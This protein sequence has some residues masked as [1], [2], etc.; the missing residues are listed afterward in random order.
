MRDIKL[1]LLCG[2]QRLP[3]YFLVQM[4]HLDFLKVGKRL[5]CCRFTILNS[6]LK[7]MHFLPSIC[8]LWRSLYG[9]PF[10]GSLPPTNNFPTSFIQPTVNFSIRTWCAHWSPTLPL[11]LLLCYPT[12]TIWL[13]DDYRSVPLSIGFVL[14]KTYFRLIF[15]WKR[16]TG[17]HNYIGF[18]F[19]SAQ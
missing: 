16:G 18:I 9:V 6:C 17:W 8:W 7:I 15:N 14:W 13:A 11:N 19:H 10:A 3:D 2:L 1:C 12:L 4:H 5:F